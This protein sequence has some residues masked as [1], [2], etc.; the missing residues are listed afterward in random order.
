MADR[1][2]AEQGLKAIHSSADIQFHRRFSVGRAAIAWQ[3]AASQQQPSAGEK[4]F[5]TGQ[6]ATGGIRHVANIHD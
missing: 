5:R 3:I 4:P 1:L 6:F 2:G